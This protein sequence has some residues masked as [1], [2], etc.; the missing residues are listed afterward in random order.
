MHYV[1]SKLHLPAIF[2]RTTDQISMQ[3]C[4]NIQ[5]REEMDISFACTGKTIQFRVMLP[6]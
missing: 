1:Q 2:S 6:D 5:Y 4:G 3:H